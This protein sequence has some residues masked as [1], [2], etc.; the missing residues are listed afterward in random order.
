MANP[1]SISA[2]SI[3]ARPLH[4]DGQLLAGGTHGGRQLTCRCQVSPAASHS[5]PFTT[6]NG[7]GNWELDVDYTG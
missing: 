5:G 4:L 3:V 2:S 7:N 6:Q 1:S